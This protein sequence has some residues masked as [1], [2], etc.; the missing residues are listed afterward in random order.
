[1]YPILF[2][3]GP[4]PI[5]TFGVLHG[6]AFAVGVWWSYRAAQRAGLKPEKIVDLSVVIFIWSLVGARV[7]SVLFDGNLSWYLQNPHEI[8]AVWKGGLTFYGGFLFGLAGGVWYVRK[9][10]LGGWQVAD[11]MAPALALGAAIGRLG[12]LASGDSF[13][14][15]TDLPWA[16]T[17]SDPHGLA[18]VGIALH[19]TQIYSV[20][21]NLAVFGILLWWRKR[22]KFKG[23]LFLVFMILYAATR[24]FVEIFRD[25]P[26]GVYLDGLIS[27]SQIVSIVV[28][29]AAI[30]YY[31]ARSK[32]RGKKRT[33]SMQETEP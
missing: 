5:H 7:F 25:D 30:V 4:F 22:Q 6:L 29:A 1:M 18:P 20:L 32:Q 31:I 12:C 13:G 3:I 17:F 24:S 21:T 16:V 14:K 2:K 19:P 11:I 23:E 33:Y 27:T 8:I 26:R 15:P 28:A 9:H 10:G